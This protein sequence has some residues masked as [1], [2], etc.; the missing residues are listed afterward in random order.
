MTLEKEAAESA[1]TFRRKHGLGVQPL[2]DLI[3]IIERST[4]ADVA[5]I[6]ADSEQHGM[7]A[8]DPGTGATFIAVA[9]TQH[10]MRQRSSLAHELAHLLFD[11]RSHSQNE[12]WAAR[13]Q[14]EIRADNFARHLLVPRDGVLQHLKGAETIGLDQLSDVVQWFGASPSICA[15]ALHD[16]KLIDAATKK[17]WM[18]ITSRDL[19]SRHG[20][21]DQYRAMAASSGR[22]R[23]PQRLLARAVRGYQLGVVSEPQ[24]RRLMGGGQKAVEN[25]LAALPSQ[26]DSTPPQWTAAGSL[27][28][29][30][31]DLS[32]LDVEPDSVA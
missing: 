4:A 11:D 19:A 2:G 29:V 7:L 9:A 26:P 3:V 21:I 8:H 32:D 5:V 22:R 1:A 20:W 17:Q 13:S 15:I 18:Q 16:A 6:N 27:P 25:L 23:A 24:I 10:P 28:A 30:S 12:T 14:E 31:T